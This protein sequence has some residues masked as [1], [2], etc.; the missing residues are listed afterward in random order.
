MTG[1]DWDYEVSRYL[2]LLNASDRDLTTPGTI[3][4]MTRDYMTYE[5][6]VNNTEDEISYKPQ[7]E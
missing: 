1:N 4:R 6:P 2:A 5:K 7:D 3:E